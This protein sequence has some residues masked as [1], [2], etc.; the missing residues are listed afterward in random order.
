MKTYLITGGAG[1]V[2][3]N[4]AIEFKNNKQNVRVVALD[5]LKRRGSELNIKRLAENGVEFIHGDI[6]NREDF[7]AVGNVDIIIECSA[8]PSVLAGLNSSPD[9]L[10]NTNL[11]G[12]INCL[13]FARK[14]DADFVFLSTS[15]VYPVK[16]I[17][18]LNFTETPTGF[19]L[20]EEQ[21][22]VGASSKGFTE[23]FTLNGTRTLYGTTKLA[24]EL[25]IQEYIEIYGLR[26]IINRCGVLTGNWQMG[27]VDQG[28]IVLW[29][30]RH[31]YQQSLNY[32]GYGG[33]GK[34]VRDILHI[35][36]LYRLLEIQINDIESHSGEIYN[37]GG[38]LERSISLCELTELC[39][40]CTG[41]KVAIASIPEDRAGDI[42]IYITDNSKV[43]EKTGWKPEIAVEQIIEE[44]YDWIKDN[45]EQLRPILA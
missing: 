13:E 20:S 33:K 2:G 24:S 3:S 31:Y 44:I 17:N 43:T 1:F 32:I 29:V 8:E 4:L 11:L 35:K 15:R 41:N 40:K 19:E 34:Q 38:G 16:T 25:I 28:V 9:Y 18:S 12:T 5:N 45:S 23:D 14:C 26:A 27:K 39:Q 37:V 30:A 10:L 42:R 21:V 6:R 22:V 36:D 7:E